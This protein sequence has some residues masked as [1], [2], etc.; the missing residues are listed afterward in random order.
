[1]TE[2]KKVQIL[3]F[4][5]LPC[6]DLRLSDGP[7]VGSFPR[8]HTQVLG[9][10]KG[11]FAAFDP[12][13]SI[14]FH[15]IPFRQSFR[16]LCSLGSSILLHGTCLQGV[17]GK[18]YRNRMDLFR[19]SMGM[20]ICESSSW[21]AKTHIDVMVGSFVFLVWLDWVRVWANVFRSSR[22]RV[23]GQD[24]FKMC[25]EV[26]SFATAESFNVLSFIAQT[27]KSTS[28]VQ[29]GRGTQ[30]HVLMGQLPWTLLWRHVFLYNRR[31]HTSSIWLLVRL[32]DWAKETRQGQGLFWEKITTVYISID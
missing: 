28:N 29:D 5:S 16:F 30:L 15:C 31:L 10:W 26:G 18:L 17:G 2:K 20:S 8:E 14:P 6:K 21:I 25:S 19:R 7:H 22:E 27:T 3:W 1:M 24:G 4:W 32:W 23:W 11:A 9:R 13:H 12:F